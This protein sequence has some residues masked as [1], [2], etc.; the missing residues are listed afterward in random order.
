MTILAEALERYEVDG[1]FFNMFGNPAADYSGVA[2]GPCQCDACQTR[3][4]ARYG[5]DVP[6]TADADYR[7]FMADS[8]RE[9]AAAIA[10]LIHRKRPQRRVPHL[11]QGPHRRHHV[12]VEHRRRPGA[13]AVAVLGE[14]QREPR[15]R[16]RAGQDRHQPVHEL[17]RL[18]VALRSRAA[19]RDRSCASTRTWRTAARRRSSWSGRW[20]SRTATGL[21]AAKP[22][23]HWHAKHEDL[24][25]GQK[26][27]ARVLLL[28]A[29]DTAS[30]RGFF[31]LLSEQ[32]I[33]FAVSENLRWLDEPIRDASIW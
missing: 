28:A 7:A 33:P 3:F 29:G 4:R 19:S 13:A 1:L 26:N 6:A 32:H 21:I 30:Y 14:R 9:V 25:V 8:S 12:R 16:F 15:A 22:V 17:R 5:R 27:A 31:R 11:H 23:F 20:T 18:S 2:M 10:E 24:Y